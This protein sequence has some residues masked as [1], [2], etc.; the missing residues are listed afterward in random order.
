MDHQQML[1]QGLAHHQNGQRAQAEALYRRVLEQQPNNVEAL[2]LL[3]VLAHEA[4][5]NDVAVELLRRAISINP[6]APELHRNI[7]RVLEALGKWDGAINAYRSAFSLQPQN[8]QVLNDLGNALR[9]RGNFDE[10]IKTLQTAIQLDPN[11]PDLH[12]N[13]A[14]TLL[15]MKQ[16]E[17]AITAAQK[18]ISLQPNFPQ[19][20]YNLGIALAQTSRKSQAVDTYEKVLALDPNFSSARSNLGI[21]LYDMGQYDQSL[22]TFRQALSLTPNDARLHYNLGNVLEK[23][24]QVEAAIASFRSAIALRPADPDAHNN[25]GCALH[26]LGR[27]DEAVIALKQALILRP[28]YAEAQT[29]MG[30]VLYEKGEVEQAIECYRKALLAKPLFPDAWNNLGNALCA[31]G[32]I[33]DAMVCF[34]KARALKPYDATVFSNLIYSMHYNPA[35]DWPAIKGKLTIWNTDH[36]QP[37]RNLIQRHDNQPD[38]ERPLRIGYVS[39]DFRQ[40]VV[41]LNMLPLL[42]EHD[43]SQF[44]ITCYAQVLRPDGITASLQPHADAWRNILGMTDADVAKLIVQDQIDILV[45]LTLHCAHHRLLVFA[46]KPAPI[47][48]SYLGYCSSTG[49]ETI[50]YRFSD[51]YLDPPEMDGE[52]IEK[53]I[54][55]PRT[56]WCYQPPSVVADPVALPA[57]SNGY[58]TFGCLN[59][60][61][62]V[63]DPALQLWAKILLSVPKS[64]LILHAQWGSHRQRVLDQFHQQG[65]AADRVEFVAKQLTQ[66]YLRTYNKIDIALDPFPYGGGITTCDALWMGVPVI[67]LEGKTAVGRGGKS[68]LSNIGLAELV[69]QSSEKYQQ[70]AATLAGDLSRLSALRSGLRKTMKS[71]SLMNAPAFAR[72]VEAAYRRV[73]REWCTV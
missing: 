40:H 56:Y 55:L 42:R 7:A 38:A 1:Q 2:H 25:L 26:S 39:P 20:I 68:I 28:V 3:A 12:N 51:P 59:N 70:I 48:F 49:V 30:N 65:V 45:D 69:A 23:K 33:D 5:R 52:Y 72:D 31:G 4:G 24:G 73:W 10:A 14:V 16:P 19:A 62:K 9:A 66:E 8:A 22:A 13:L 11:L 50:D 67:T 27:M 37:L 46:R 18:A 47:Q 36:A 54:R 58:I 34:V 41:G 43:R 32:L 15:E 71:S 6:M 57:V 53:T 21:L 63:S 61:A 44:K 60:F 64:R 29:N 35:Y 17:Q